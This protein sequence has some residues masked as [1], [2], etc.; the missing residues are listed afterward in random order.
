MLA[1][2]AGM[3]SE[4]QERRMWQ[5]R[6]RGKCPGL[7]APCNLAFAVLEHTALKRGAE[8]PQVLQMEERKAEEGRRQANGI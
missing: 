5:G 7:Q 1:S 6:G 2:V 4:G 8:D 3:M